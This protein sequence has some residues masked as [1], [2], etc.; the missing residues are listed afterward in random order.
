MQYAPAAQDAL[1]SLD[2]LNNEALSENEIYYP[3]VCV[4]SLRDLPQLGLLRLGKG[5]EVSSMY[6]F[7]NPF[8]EKHTN[9][10]QAP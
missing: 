3:Y 7:S 9:F 2:R 1:E 8:D 6:P 5:F 4:K 10:R